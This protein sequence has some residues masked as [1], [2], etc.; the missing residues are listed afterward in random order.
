MMVTKPGFRH[1]DYH[2]LLL[3]AIFI[4][5]GALIFRPTIHGNDTVGYYSWL[6]SAVID[7]NLNSGDEFRHYGY[8]VERES[9]ATGYTINPYP[10]GSAILWLPF[11]LIAHGI[12]LLLH[13]IGLPI[14][15]DGYGTQYIVAVSLGSACYGLIA[16]LL[17][18]SLGREIFNSK[19]A[20]LATIS[21]WLAG[22]LIFYMYAHPLMSHAN[23]AFAYTLFA[24]TWYRTRQI[25]TWR[26]G[27]LRGATAALCALVRQVNAYLVIFVIAEYLIQ[28]LGQW[29]NRPSRQQVRPSFQALIAF[30]ALWWVVYLPQLVTWLVVFGSWAEFNHYSAG[31]QRHFSWIHPHLPEVLFSTN[32]GLF[33]WTPLFLLAVIGWW[34]LRRKDLRLTLFMAANF[35]LHWYVV[36]AWFWWSGAAAFGQRFFTNFLAAWA[37]GL[38][39]LFYAWQK[40]IKYSWLVALS[41]MFVIWNGLLL[42]RYAVGDVPRTGPVSFEELIMGQFTALPRYFHRVVH[43][44]LTRS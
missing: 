2:V 39:A 43:I 11:F 36:S 6:R 21:S 4:A 22:P 35:T 23:D 26:T 12:S 10:I 44:I 17:T 3:F 31:V 20:L 42:I 29:K 34:Y 14:T 7:H 24:Y 15:L 28:I 38:G 33:L 13:G 27:A 16:V 8:A 30:V 5:A 9:A 25:T 37:L 18:Y 1:L 40:R 41:A 32:R 19:T